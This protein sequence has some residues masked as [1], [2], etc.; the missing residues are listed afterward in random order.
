MQHLDDIVN[1]SFAAADINQSSDHHPDHIF[2]KTAAFYIN[3][4]ERP[5]LRQRDGKNF[6][7]RGLG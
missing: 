2:Q 5:L 1:R 3:I 4:H 7:D 6:P